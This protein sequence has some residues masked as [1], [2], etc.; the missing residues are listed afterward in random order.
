M[1]AG[2]AA[3]VSG[4]DADKLSRRP[5]AVLMRWLL[6]AWNGATLHAVFSKMDTNKCAFPMLSAH[7]FVWVPSSWVA[8]RQGFRGAE[9]A[10]AE[11]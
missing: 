6:M 5:K 9:V 2:V 3:G 10:E 8:N 4:K 11:C 1:V 7:C